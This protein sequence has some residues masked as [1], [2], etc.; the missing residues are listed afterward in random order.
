MKTIGLLK[1]IALTR[2]AD[3][4]TDKERYLLQQ[5]RLKEL[6]FYAKTNSPYFAK[7]YQ[8]VDENAS[9]SSLP[10]TNKAEMMAHFDEWLTDRSISKDKVSRL[11]LTKRFYRPSQIHYHI[12]WHH[13][14]SKNPIV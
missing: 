3:K 5:K 8:G 13:R 12:P 1:T 9:L 2:K 7:L 6:V 10:T 14:F 4:M 11:V